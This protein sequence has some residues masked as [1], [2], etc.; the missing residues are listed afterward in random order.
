MANSPPFEQV[1]RTTRGRLWLHLGN[2]VRFRR[3][4]LRIAPPRAAAHVGVAL[5]TYEEYEA[6]ERLIPADQLAE[7]A[8][9]FAVPMFYFFEDL[10]I[11]DDASQAK[12]PRSDPVYAIANETD[13]IAALI[14]DF[15][16]LD[17][18]R[19]QHLLMVARAL[20]NATPRSGTSG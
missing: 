16:N 15:Q 13:R 7:L 19:Q 4:Q 10:Q 6:G 2:R 8:E 9:L 3:E 20:A 1:A 17:F 18:E 5:R 14:E 12:H 11:G